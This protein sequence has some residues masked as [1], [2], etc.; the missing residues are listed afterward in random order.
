MCFN[1]KNLKLSIRKAAKLSKWNSGATIIFFPS[2]S[3]I[4][5]FL[6]HCL[7]LCKK[8]T[9][10]NGK[11]A[12]PR[13]CLCQSQQQTNTVFLLF[14]AI[15]LI[16]RILIVNYI[17]FFHFLLLFFCWYNSALFVLFYKLLYIFLMYLL[18]IKSPNYASR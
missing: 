5:V 2:F 14:F 13:T 16:S 8:G 3:S 1:G 18:Q 12:F 17:I 6:H 15:R 4:S 10:N 7:S 9:S 11:T